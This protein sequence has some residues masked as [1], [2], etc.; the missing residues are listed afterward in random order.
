SGTAHSTLSL[1]RKST[2][3]SAPRYSSVW[4]FCRPK[5]LTS[6]TVMPDTPTS[7]SASRTSSSLN[8]RMIATISFISRLLVECAGAASER[9]ADG[10][11]EG[12]IGQEVVV[13]VG[14]QSLLGVGVAVGR[15]DRE[16]VVEALGHA[17][18]PVG[19]LVGLVVL[20]PLLAAVQVQRPA[21]LEG[22]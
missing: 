19:V 20:D 2:T 11:G 3:Y 8:G 21:R 1:G 5:P 7:V 15:G 6:V 22:P 13:R 17:E 12:A 10:Q 16:A 9:L 14:V 18:L 4:P